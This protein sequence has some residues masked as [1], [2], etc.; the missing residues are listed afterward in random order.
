M[1][2]QLLALVFSLSNTPRI[3]FTLVKLCIKNIRAANWGT[4]DV[5]WLVM[6]LTLLW[7]TALKYAPRMATKKIL[8]RIATVKRLNLKADCQGV[9]PVV[10]NCGIVAQLPKKSDNQYQPFYIESH[11]VHHLIY[12]QRIV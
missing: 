11:P 1:V 8:L 7:K 5:K 4:A 9:I 3:G 12:E 10:A 2:C 6:D